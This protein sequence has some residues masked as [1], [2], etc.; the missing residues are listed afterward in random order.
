MTE[1]VLF[2]QRAETKKNIEMDRKQ[3]IQDIDQAQL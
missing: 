2:E 3:I 1:E